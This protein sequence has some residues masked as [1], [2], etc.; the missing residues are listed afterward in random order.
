MTAHPPRHS[1]DSLK[2]EAKRWLAALRANDAEARARLERALDND[3]PETPTLRA[4]QHALAREHGF[5]GWA[6][7][8]EAVERSL[9]AARDAGAT[10]LARYEA[11]AEALVEAYR[12]GTPDAMERH[13]YY[14]WHRRSWHAMR[15]YVQLDLGKRPAHHDD[16][17]EITLDDGRHLV[18][19][20]HGFTS[21]SELQTF[22]R[23][24]QVARNVAAKPVRMVLL[25]GADEPETLARSRDWDEI[26]GL[27][28][29]NPGTG[30]G[31][32][33]QMTDNVLAELASRVET[34]SALDLSGSKELTDA[35]V[36]HLARLRSLE[37]LDLSGTGVTD[38]G[39]DVLRGLPRLRTISLA[40][41]RVTD[42]GILALAPC[43]DL[44]RV[45]LAATRAGDGALRALA[46]KEKLR[47]LAIG[48][49]DA[50]FPLLHELPV[51]KAW[52]GGEAELGLLGSKSMPN[53][54]SLR[55]S[56][57]D[58]GIQHLR[59]LDGLF[60]LDLDDSR[61]GITAAGLEPLVDLPHLGALGV[62][63]KDDW[64]PYVA[65]MPRLRFL[66]VQD[67]TAGDEGF[68]A[69]SRSRSI[70]YIWGR[71]CHNLHRRG[72][73]A[74]AAMPALRGLS[75][76]CLNVD[77][78]GVAALPTFPALKELMPMDVPDAGY[79]H[80]GRCEQLRSLILMYCRDTT[81]AATAH[82]TGLPHLSYYFN[83]YTTITDR[84]PE[85][86]S[87]MDSLER[88]TFDACHGLTNAGVARLARLPRLRELRVSGRGLTG[89]VRNAFPPTVRVS[90][91]P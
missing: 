59:G 55:G 26:L 42:Q 76:S 19:R 89:E 67:T 91:E 83:S 33:G 49:S 45:N 11:A 2:R 68:V 82:I 90:C 57:T 56:F 66:T 43:H 64:M 75:V 86:L 1:L 20:E 30:L 14:T 79:R 51:F 31:A 12:T 87:T 16:D 78:D 70:E 50:G 61:L 35:G 4:V 52:Q 69:L 60:G 21:W 18:A 85:L 73:V 47:H 25:D 9:A 3:T 80:V 74:L 34:I 10:A 28:A 40:W 65:A 32:E 62:D 88:V 41:T 71:R 37:Y 27:L 46:G 29:S 39:I 13:Y 7:L 24:A 53:Q 72:F 8:K 77:E 22:T 63:A 38:A 84:T 54:L 81:D 48:L 5:A 44:E 17:I 15:T 36:R 58:R 23:S 6:L